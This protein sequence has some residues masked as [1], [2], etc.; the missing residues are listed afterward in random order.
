MPTLRFSEQLQRSGLNR[1]WG[2]DA[3]GPLGTACKCSGVLAE[4]D[5]TTAAAA[6]HLRSSLGSLG[7]KRAL[8]PPHLP[9]LQSTKPPDKHSST[10]HPRKPSKKTISSKASTDVGPH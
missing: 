3:S 8:G 2:L 1:I 6:K 10:R 4:Q 5:R 7:R 9:S